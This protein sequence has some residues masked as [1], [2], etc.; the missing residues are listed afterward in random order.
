MKL[1][2]LYENKNVDVEAQM[3]TLKSL[4]FKFEKTKDYIEAVMVKKSKLGIMLVD[5]TSQWY[6]PLTPK[7][8]NQGSFYLGK[9]EF[10]YNKQ[11]G[12]DIDDFNLFVKV[13]KS[14]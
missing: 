10:D 3:Q 5:V 2:H 8:N 14:L 4:G 7:T 1:K 13:V 9:Y 12:I 6:I 11:I